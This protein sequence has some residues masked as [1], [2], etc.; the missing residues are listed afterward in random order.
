ML[1]AAAMATS[2][3][4]PTPSALQ[5]EAPAVA[6]FAAVA[7]QVKRLNLQAE[8][9]GR[10]AAGP[11]LGPAT[12]V[13]HGRVPGSGRKHKIPLRDLGKQAPTPVVNQTSAPQSSLGADD[14][15]PLPHPPRIASFMFSQAS[16]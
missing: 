7:A 9:S 13:T 15:L 3:E 5:A 1:D 11:E 14:P 6:E 8:G 4:G 16:S 12:G 2:P 10:R